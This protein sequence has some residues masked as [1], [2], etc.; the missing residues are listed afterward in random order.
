MERI[1]SFIEHNLFTIVVI[2][3]GIFAPGGLTIAVFNMRYFVELD[4]FKLIY[5]SFV[6][7][8][9]IFSF[10]FIV[11]SFSREAGA[12]K[13]GK[14]GIIFA[15]FFNLMLFGVVLFIKIVFI[16]FTKKQFVI[17]LFIECVIV[18]W[19]AREDLIKSYKESTQ[20]DNN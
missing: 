16:D 6:I 2:G 1:A 17:A 10:L 19:I 14:T 13:E 18:L 9:P 12:R 15:S 3:F 5:L 11:Y 4:V 7:S 8:G 20:S